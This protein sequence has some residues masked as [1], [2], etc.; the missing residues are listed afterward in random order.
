VFTDLHLEVVEGVDVDVL[1]LLPEPH[2]VV[3]QRQDVGA[4]LAVVGGVVEA[5][6]RHVGGAYGLDLLQLPVLILT[7][8][9]RG[10]GATR[11]GGEAGGRG[12]ILLTFSHL[13]A[14]K[15]FY[16]PF[17]CPLRY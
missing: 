16:V 2:G 14:A 13:A 9:L 3:G 4:A 7:D 11:R 8:D 12:Y 1:H 17:K 6:R 10:G 15:R 5:R